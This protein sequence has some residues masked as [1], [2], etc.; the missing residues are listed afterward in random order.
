M[1]TIMSKYSTHYLIFC[2]SVGLILGAIF[3][4]PW[5]FLVSSVWYMYYLGI[6]II[7]YISHFVLLRGLNKDPWDMYIAFMLSTTVKLVC[8]AILLG[9][10]LYFYNHEKVVLILNFFVLYFSYTFFEIKSLLLSLHPH[11]ESSAPK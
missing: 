6:S 2:L 1:A 8:C 4:S 7:M 5:S 3:Y 9:I 10:L 11:S